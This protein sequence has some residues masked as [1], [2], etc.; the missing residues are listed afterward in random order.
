[1]ARVDAWIVRSRE[2]QNGGVTSSIHHVVIGRVRVERAEQIG[3]LDRA[4]LRDI[5]SS[6]GLELDASMSNS[7]VRPDG[8]VRSGCCV[9]AA[10]MR[11]PPLPPPSAARREERWPVVDEPVCGGGE[12]VEDT[13]AASAPGAVPGVAVPA[14]AAILASRRDRAA[15]ASG[16]RGAWG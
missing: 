14:A 16:R 8:A 15:A 4:E 2:K 1:V 11:R 3:L 12:N 10:P 7:N 6:V 5:E 13:F 9:S